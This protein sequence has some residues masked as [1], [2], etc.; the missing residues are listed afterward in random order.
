V[1]REGKA[2]MKEIVVDVLG[3]SLFTLIVFS[4]FFYQ[5]IKEK[6]SDEKK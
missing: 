5:Y 3:N 4:P 2:S 1:V 6:I